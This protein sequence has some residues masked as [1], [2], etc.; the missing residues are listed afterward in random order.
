MKICARHY[1]TIQYRLLRSVETHFVVRDAFAARPRYRDNGN[2]FIAILEFELSR[3]NLKSSGL[4]SQIVRC[5]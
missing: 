3:L 2:I 4:K 1:L 5:I